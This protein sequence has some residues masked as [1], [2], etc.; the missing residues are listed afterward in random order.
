MRSEL[1]RE[2]DPK[3]GDMAF[4]VR[5]SA[6]DIKGLA[7]SSSADLRALENGGTV[8][9]K[10]SALSR[11]ASAIEAKHWQEHGWKEELAAVEDHSAELEAAEQEQARQREAHPA[12]IIGYEYFGDGDFSEVYAPD[13]PDL[14]AARE[15]AA[16]LFRIVSKER[17]DRD[18]LMAYGHLSARYKHYTM[19]T[20]SNA[21][22][23]FWG[24]MSTIVG[25]PITC[26]VSVVLPDG[27]ERKATAATYMEAIAAIERGDYHTRPY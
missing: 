16:R 21:R 20:N 11:I 19:A 12:E 14:V 25:G 6:A 3:T 4:T 2:D 23:I 7:G 1:T 27:E 24:G 26:T 13:H 5:I 17:S 18:C 15:E 10:L 22:P 9:A 8:A